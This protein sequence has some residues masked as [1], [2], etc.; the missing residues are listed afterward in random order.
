MT[1]GPVFGSVAE[2]HS[3]FR[4]VEI[5]TSNAVINLFVQIL[6][7]VLDFVLFV[8]ALYDVLF[9]RRMGGDPTM[10]T[11]DPAGVRATTFNNPH[12]RDRS[13]KGK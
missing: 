12:F 13:K 1:L 4:Y 10:T 8:M 3:T 9:A 11:R 7:I 5:M 6:V 2:N